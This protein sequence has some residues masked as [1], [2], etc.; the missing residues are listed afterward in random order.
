MLT[1]E[2][3]KDHST[4]N[5]LG[6]GNFVRSFTKSLRNSRLY[7]THT[8]LEN[9]KRGVMFRIRTPVNENHSCK[10]RS[11]VATGFD[12]KE[13]VGGDGESNLCGAVAD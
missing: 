6:S 3:I 9:R 2:E 10:D 8:N 1:Q 5:I 11:N 7:N 13:N 12:N 4:K